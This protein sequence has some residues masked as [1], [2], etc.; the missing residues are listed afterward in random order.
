MEASSPTRTE[1]TA[2]GRRAQRA[3]GDD[4]ER[5]ILA[6]AQSL[7]EERPLSE[8]SVDD[9][10]RGAGISRP[11][12]YFYFPS[13]DAVLLTLLE[14]VIEEA[15]ARL[16]GLADPLPADPAQGWRIGITAFFEA[17]GAHRPVARAAAPA[18]I[19]NSEV[20]ALWST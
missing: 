5:A 7:L 4:R 6:T 2:R 20:R 15:S 11:T 3:S 10:A 12:F 19:T 9:L 8:I 13:K 14:R 17:F 18:R 16:D 1:G